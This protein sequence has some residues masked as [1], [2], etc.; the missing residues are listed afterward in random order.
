METI[1]NYINWY[2]S[3]TAANW[4][5]PAYTVLLGIE[6][7]FGRSARASWRDIRFNYIY[8]VIVLTILIFLRP[9]CAAA[10]EAIAKPFGGPYVDLTFG[11]GGSIWKNIA[12][13]ASF[14]LVYDFFY[15]WHHRWQ[16]ASAFAWVTHKLH[17]SDEDLGITTAYKHHW[18]D[19]ALRT[20]TILIPMAIIFKFEPVTIFWVVYIFSL[21]G[22]MIHMNVNLSFGWFDRFTPSPNIHRVH[23]SKLLEHRDKNFAAIFSF[24]DCAFGTFHPAER[25][26]PPTG[27]DT[28][29][30]FESMLNAYNYPFKEW[31]HM[32]RPSKSEQS[33][34]PLK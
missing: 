9:W 34:L 27:L 32:L 11:A 15:Y 12:A 8:L 2:V 14:I 23:H 6:L 25:V 7:L 18:T 29:E 31:F 4:V 5:F 10:A 28:G 13:F 33:S 22:L 20:L 16:H 21:Q 30:K 26:A 19:E 1:H 3:H 24:W 17:H